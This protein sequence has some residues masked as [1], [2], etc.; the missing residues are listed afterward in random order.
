MTHRKNKLAGTEMRALSS[1]VLLLVCLLVTALMGTEA[2]AQFPD[3][4]LL[5]DIAK[6][7]TGSRLIRFHDEVSIPASQ[8]FG[9]HGAKFGLSENDQMI[10]TD[11]S[12]DEE[13]GLMHYRFQQYH[14]GIKVDGM[15]Y[16]VRASQERCET[17]NGFIMPYLNVPS[18]PSIQQLVALVAALEHIGAETYM[19]E[20]PA[21][22]S[23]LKVDEEDSLATY[24]PTG[25][26]VIT[27]PYGVYDTTAFKLAWELKIF[28]AEPM[29]HDFVYIDAN[30]G[31]VL[32]IETLMDAA[33]TA[34]A[35]L[36]Y[37]G[38]KSIETKYNLAK[39]KYRLKDG[40]RGNGIRVRD[41][42]EGTSES[43][44]EDIWHGDT[45]WENRPIATQAMWS[46]EQVWDYYNDVHGL[47]S[48]NGS[49]KKVKVYIHWKKDWVN[50]MWNGGSFVFGDG[51]G[52]DCQALVD[53]DIC[54]HEFTHGVDY[55]HT[56]F[57]G[58]SESGALEES[59]CDIFGTLIEHHADPTNANW[60]IGEQCTGGTGLRDM[61]DPEGKGH[62]D[63]YMDATWYTGSDN[64]KYIH[65]NNGVQNFWFYLLAE[66][67]SGVN[68]N[69]DSYDVT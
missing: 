19:W 67:G 9:Q 26:L 64:S 55:Y 43:A 11:S 40:T 60:L 30:T 51:D 14:N 22:D 49:G 31:E 62:P 1:F 36:K 45:Y 46:F 52:T 5:H 20:I 29:S 50:A 2:M 66:G 34:T 54:G 35:E 48:F 56:K 28:A 58:S 24:F 23:L 15:Q 68:D 37:N 8:L 21:E 3:A 13:T 41:A 33:T 6:V 57:K 38:T 39:N 65:R 47:K 16:V 32:K 25:E 7:R 42:N 12:F 10:V 61:A 18:E 17:A 63:C 27:A 4:E 53:L 69:N 44:A 59:F